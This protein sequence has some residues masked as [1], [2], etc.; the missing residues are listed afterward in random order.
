MKM[1]KRALLTSMLTAI[2]LLT[3]GAFLAQPASAAS[4]DGVCDSGEFCY[5]YNSGEAGAVSDFTTSVSDYGTTEPSCYDFKGS[6]AGAGTCIK[7]NAASVWNRSSKTVRVYF[8][9]GYAGASE[10]FAPGAKVN[11]DSTLKNENASHQFLA[12]TPTGCTTDGTNTTAPST[13]LVY[14]V[15]SGTVD[16]V[17]F[18]TYVENV[19]PNEWIS[20]WAPESLKA[21]A[22]AV[23]SYG[24]YWAMHS[25]RRTS[26]GACFDVWDNTNSQ[27][28]KPGT[29]TSATNSA[30]TSTWGTRMTRSGDILE[31]SYCSTTT[32]CG[33]WN[34]GNEMSQYGSE[35]L[36]NGGDSYSTILH[37][38]YSNI[39]LGS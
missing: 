12:S 39:V 4:R 18:E 8:N 2:A 5:Y 32:A 16:R 9:T 14:R 35:D 36:A 11:L 38:Y 21:G 24:W 6:G 34:T 10:D 19:L 23:K 13:I 1:R 15:A 20:S 30:V 28:Y 31:A 27:V 26:S 7:N 22:M 25:T 37:Y 3:S 33:T 17:N 29:A